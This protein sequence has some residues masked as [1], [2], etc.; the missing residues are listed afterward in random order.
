MSFFKKVLGLGPKPEEK[1]KIFL[2]NYNFRDAVNISDLPGAPVSGEIL[3]KVLVELINNR[4]VNGRTVGKKGWFLP[5]DSSR[6]DGIFKKLKPKQFW[7]C[8]RVARAPIKR[9]PNW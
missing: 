3:G 8:A 4:K 5:G 7:S 2:L 1:A 9:L 6:F